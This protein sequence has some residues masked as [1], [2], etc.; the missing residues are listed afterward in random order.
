M[1]SR[2]CTN[3]SDKTQSRLEPETRTP[4]TTT[5]MS[6]PKSIISVGI[7]ATPEIHT[8]LE[9]GKTQVLQ[10]GYDFE[11]IIFPVTD[12][13]SELPKIKE[14]LCAKHW[15]G[16]VIGFGVRGNPKHTEILETL[17]N[18]A[19]ESVPGVKFGFSSTPED[20]LPC[21]ERIFEKGQ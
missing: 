8:K 7:T 21:V 10:A 12:F 13:S 6:P 18:A 19:S 16:V 9:V 15:D 4:T 2:A 17:V 11:M 1:S 3:T 14:R 5:A 20:L